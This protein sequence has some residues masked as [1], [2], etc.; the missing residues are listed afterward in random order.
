MTGYIFVTSSGMSQ[1]TRIHAFHLLLWCA[2]SSKLAPRN[3]TNSNQ[4]RLNSYHPR[5]NVEKEHVK[6]RAENDSSQITIHMKWKKGGKSPTYKQ[7]KVCPLQI[8][9]KVTTHQAT[10]WSNQ[11][12]HMK[13]LQPAKGLFPRPLFTKQ[14]PMFSKY[15]SM[16]LPLMHSENQWRQHATF[17]VPPD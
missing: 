17:W 8:W 15:R 10:T 11:W 5:K 3:S 16:F 2:T 4:C 1:S 14:H 13:K 9:T 12:L 7:I 6:R